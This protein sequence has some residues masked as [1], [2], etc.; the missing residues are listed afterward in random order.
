M[1]ENR[2]ILPLIIKKKK[3]AFAHNTSED[4]ISRVTLNDAQRKKESK[5]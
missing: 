4:L 3:E 5:K 2:K 1:A